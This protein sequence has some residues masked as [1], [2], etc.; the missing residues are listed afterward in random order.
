MKRM[1][2]VLCS[3]VLA[4]AACATIDSNVNTYGS[5][6]DLKPTEASTVAVLRNAPSREYV[7]LGQVVVNS[8]YSPAPS[9]EA[10]QERLRREAAS[11]GADAVIVVYDDVQPVNAYSVAA[12]PSAS[13]E[14]DPR[15]RT[16]GVAIK[17]R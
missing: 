14:A 6:P 10:V 12:Q 7:R 3:A 17:Y 4:L 16:I 2:L 11:I 8:S 5:F 1:Y 9:A 15:R 13:K